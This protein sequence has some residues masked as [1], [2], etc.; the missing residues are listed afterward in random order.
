M[1]FWS[2][3]A[4]YL[5][6]VPKRVPFRCPFCG[7][8]G[9]FRK[10]GPT[11]GVHWKVKKKE[12]NKWQILLFPGPLLVHFSDKTCK[13][14]GPK[15]P[16]KQ[17]CVLLLSGQPRYR[18]SGFPGGARCEFYTVNMQVEWRYAFFSGNLEIDAPRRREITFG[19]HF[20]GPGD[21]QIMKKTIWLDIFFC[22]F[23]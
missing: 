20:G 6:K 5:K 9:H 15:L 16:L 12:T 3:G 4:N 17:D 19:G 13:K 7:L 21:T 23:F 10:M 2:F 22:V 11:R 1:R 8:W 14:G 18:K